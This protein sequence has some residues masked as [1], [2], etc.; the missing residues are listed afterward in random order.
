M[1]GILLAFLITRLAVL[2]LYAP[3]IHDGDQVH[4]TRVARSIM[5]HGLSGFFDPGYIVQKGSYYPWFEN[6]HSLPD[7]QYNSIFWDGVWNGLASPRSAK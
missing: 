2:V 1:A 5:D 7:G 3:E 4:Y 6:N